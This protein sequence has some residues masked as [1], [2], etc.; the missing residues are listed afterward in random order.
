MMG[1]TTTDK[2]TKESKK[3]NRQ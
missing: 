2:D 1:G 3:E